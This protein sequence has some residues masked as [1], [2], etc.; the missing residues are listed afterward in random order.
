MHYI[1]TA[2]SRLD[3]VIIE[4]RKQFLKHR[5]PGWENLAPFSIFGRNHVQNGEVMKGRLFDQAILLANGLGMSRAQFFLFLDYVLLVPIPEN[6]YSR[7]QPR[8]E[9]AFFRKAISAYDATLLGEY[10]RLEN[11]GI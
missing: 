6:P 2:L 4:L 1:P 7:P 5:G 10:G 11:T 8:Y 9:K 3:P